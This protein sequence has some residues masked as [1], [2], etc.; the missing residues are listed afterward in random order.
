MKKPPLGYIPLAEIAEALFLARPHGSEGQAFRT[1]RLCCFNILTVA[2]RGHTAPEAQEA[3]R[4][5]CYEGFDKREVK[6]G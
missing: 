1:W 6:N 2:Q 4:K 5:A 3:F